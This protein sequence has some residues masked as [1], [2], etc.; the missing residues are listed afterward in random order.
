[1]DAVIPYAMSLATGLAVGAAY[2]LLAVK[3]PAP[4]VIALIG[5]LGILVGEMAVSHLRGHPDAAAALL[6]RKSFAVER[7]P[8]PGTVPALGDG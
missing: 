8:A 6:H 1:M 4:P 3:S 7:A 2:G 5:L